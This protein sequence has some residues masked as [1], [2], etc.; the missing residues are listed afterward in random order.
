MVKSSKKINIDPYVNDTIE[1]YYSN[2]KIIKSVRKKQLPVSDTKYYYNSI[3]NID[4]IVSRPLRYDAEAK[5]GK[6]TYQIKS[7][8]YKLLKT[9]TIL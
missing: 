9:T 6:L 4:S 1:Y 8:L 3:G 2:D 7:K 5:L